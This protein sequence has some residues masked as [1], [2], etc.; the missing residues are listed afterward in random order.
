[1]M[2]SEFSPLLSVV[3]VN[4]NS[5]ELLRQS[6]NSVLDTPLSL[7][8]IVSD[9]NSSDTSLD[10]LAEISDGDKR[11][12]LIRNEDNYGFAVAANKAILKSKGKYI[13]LLNPDCI[14]GKDTL[15]HMIDV[16]KDYPNAGMAGCL[17]LNPDGTEQVGCRRLIP[18][19]YR[20]LKRALNLDRIFRKHPRFQ[21]FNMSG[22]PL[23]EG[24]VS[25]EA[26]SGAFMCIR[27]SV[28]D[29]IGLLDEK[30]FLHCEDLDWCMRFRNAGKDI[31]FVP[32]ASAVHYQGTCSKSNP[33]K[34]LW[35][36]HIGMVIF[37]RKFLRERYPLPLMFLVIMSVWARFAILSLPLLIKATFTRSRSEKDVSNVAIGSVPDL[38]PGN[39]KLFDPESINKDLLGE[40]VLVTGGSGF[41]GS[42]LIK[43]IGKKTPVSVLSRNETLPA[44]QGYEGVIDVIQGDLAVHESMPE[45]M[46]E[47]VD[48]VIHLASYVHKNKD[49]EVDENHFTITEDGTRY[50]IRKAVEAGVKKFVYVSSVKA[51]GENTDTI[52]DEK[53]GCKPESPYGISKLTAEKLVLELGKEHGVHVCVLRLPM[54]YG[55]GN[56]GNLPKMIAQI[57]RRRFPPLPQTHNKRSMVHVDDVVQAILLSIT[58]EEANGNVYIVTDGNSYSTYQIYAEIVKSLKGKIPFLKVPVIVFRILSKLGDQIGK[59]S[60][61]PFLFNSDVFRKLFDS[62]YYSSDKIQRELG[63]KPS[64]TFYS[65]LPDMIEEYRK[66][67]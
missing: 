10:R 61:R 31:L 58:R 9:N 56:K 37:Y 64:R 5:G 7:E 20:S 67:Q 14:V 66:C 63:Y 62:A 25:T 33:V 55:E 11:V 44:I 43:A 4:Y 38:S 53:T 36:K 49:K 60:G 52:A 3:I 30:Y 2:S 46:F 34:V 24:P 28:L 19:P 59:M 65:A 35:Y 16:M 32:E 18:T 29:E 17:I 12:Q 47:N 42:R 57:D 8:V 6:V 15:M 50:L 1:M 22:T 45:R 21:S 13:L 23:P 48:S 51:M 54:V 26:I 41:I 39:N 27:R 40:R